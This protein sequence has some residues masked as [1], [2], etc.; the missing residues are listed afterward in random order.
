M[1]FEASE[2]VRMPQV[3]IEVPAL[4]VQKVSWYP[5]HCI[6]RALQDDRPTKPTAAI[7]LVIDDTQKIKGIL[8]LK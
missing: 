4:L 8:K 2:T 1:A 6:I 3:P 5:E 7:L